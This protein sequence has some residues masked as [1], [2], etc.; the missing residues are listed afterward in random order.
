MK[1]F[2]FQVKLTTLACAIMIRPKLIAGM[3][4]LKS[5]CDGSPCTCCLWLLCFHF[6]GYCQTAV[7]LLANLF[8][9]TL[10][11]HNRS[12]NVP[13]LLQTVGGIQGPT[14]SSKKCPPLGQTLPA[15]FVCSLYPTNVA[16]TVRFQHPGYNSFHYSFS[17]EL[18]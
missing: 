10:T 18:I 15:I 6:T 8:H 16:I 14:P 11:H 5:F 12:C 2:V 1:L 9:P 17:G 13:V 7:L 3:L 4:T